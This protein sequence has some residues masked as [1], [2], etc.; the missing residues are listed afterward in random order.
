M[1]LRIKLKHRNYIP[2]RQYIAFRA[3][4]IDIGSDPEQTGMTH[5][6]T[7]ITWCLIKDRMPY[8]IRYEN[9][10][11]FITKYYQIGPRIS[12]VDMVRAAFPPKEILKTAEWWPQP[13]CHI[14][15]PPLP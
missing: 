6:Y 13:F 14:K 12:E 4:H 15:L 1:R 5:H 7:V 2:I 11:R 3:L 8:A 10:R 9:C